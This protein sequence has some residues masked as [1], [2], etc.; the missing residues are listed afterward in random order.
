MNR[1]LLMV[2]LAFNL[3]VMGSSLYLMWQRWQK[4]SSRKSSIPMMAA[5][6]SQSTPQIQKQPTIPVASVP[7]D[8]VSQEKKAPTTETPRQKKIN[9]KRKI[10]FQYRD[11]IPKRVSI[12]GSFNQWSP[13]LMKKGEGHL[14]S[15]ALE[16]EPGTYAYNFVVDGRV[17]RDPNNKK[18]K[19]ANQK[20]PSSLLIVPFPKK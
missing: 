7:A 5:T 4:Y 8:S 18:T 3:F 20:I 9:P 6:P 11:S 1:E 14:W 19:Q 15:I 16:L 12:I 13:Q 2:L 10:V 17:I